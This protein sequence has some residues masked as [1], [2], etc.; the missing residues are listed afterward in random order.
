M[1]VLKISLKTSRYVLDFNPLKHCL[2]LI[3][4]GTFSDYLFDVCSLFV[5]SNKLKNAPINS[6]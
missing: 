6:K 4:G 2:I 3:C 5:G 1:S